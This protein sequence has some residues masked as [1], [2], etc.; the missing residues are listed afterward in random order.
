VLHLSYFAF[1]E[2]VTLSIRNHGHIY[3]MGDLFSK[4]FRWTI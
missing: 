1:S 2:R 3:W 4:L